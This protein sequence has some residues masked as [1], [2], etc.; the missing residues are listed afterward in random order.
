M[1][2]EILMKNGL[3]NRESEVATL[4]AKGLSNKDVADKLY[5]TEK[6][7]KFH[8]TNIYKKMNIRSRAQLIVWSLPYVQFVGDNE[9]TSGTPAPFSD[10]QATT[11]PEVSTTPNNGDIN[12]IPLARGRV[13]FDGS[14]GSGSNQGGNQGEAFGA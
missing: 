9:G 7:I 4:V 13:P 1:L 3:S 10:R 5:V 6:T 14:Q 8:L 2:R 12:I 11:A